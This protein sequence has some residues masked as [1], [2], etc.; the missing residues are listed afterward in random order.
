MEH[1]PHFLP[2]Y[3]HAR[4]FGYSLE[5]AR[6]DGG[7]P[8]CH[9]R[10]RQW[11]G[12]GAPGTGWGSTSFLVLPSGAVDDPALAPFLHPASDGCGAKA[13]RLR[14]KATAME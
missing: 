4:S 5:M 14:G 3:M 2:L 8:L 13:L 12:L 9:D 7:A 11:S 1:T 10:S 6:H